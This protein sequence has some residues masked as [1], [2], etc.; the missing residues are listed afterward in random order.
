MNHRRRKKPRATEINNGV[1]MGKCRETIFERTKTIE[2]IERTKSGVTRSDRI[3][4]AIS[5]SD[6]VDG[7]VYGTLTYGGSVGAVG[8]SAR[9]V[10]PVLLKVASHQRVE[11]EKRK[12]ESITVGD[13]AAVRTNL[14]CLAVCCTNRVLSQ[15]L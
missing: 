1:E 5:Q 12:Y 3:V 8:P 14:S 2:L 15:K 9:H 7:D 4:R 6:T 11:S 13:G 10:G